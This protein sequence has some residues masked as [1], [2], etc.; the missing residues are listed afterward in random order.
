[1]KIRLSF[2][3]NSSSSCFIVES[4]ND[5]LEGFPLRAAE[6][7]VISQ[8]TKELELILDCYNKIFKEDLKF[9]EV[10]RK[11]FICDKKFKK[12]IKFY[13]DFNGTIDC[14]NKPIVL[15][16]TDN[17]I[18]SGLFSILEEKFNTIRIHMG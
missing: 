13:E 4:Y 8:I 2:V 3:A 11:P 15:S 18:P 17:S 12:E 9:E 5:I 1:M 7:K 16:R 10:F 6:D 14:D